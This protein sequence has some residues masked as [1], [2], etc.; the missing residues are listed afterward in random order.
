MTPEELFDLISATSI[1]LS[2]L[3]SG[4]NS[5]RRMLAQIALLSLPFLLIY[6][7]QK[8]YYLRKKQFSAWPQFPP[9]LTWGHLKGL[10]EFINQGEKDRHIGL[11][12]ISF[13]H[14]PT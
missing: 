11:H 7:A 8:V 1:E 3:V 13:I 6:L 12:F 5:N 10:Q 4:K 9:S 2:F 14:P